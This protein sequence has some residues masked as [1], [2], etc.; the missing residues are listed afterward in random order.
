MIFGILTSGYLCL[1]FWNYTHYRIIK[2]NSQELF[3][4]SGAVGTAILFVGTFLHALS[5]GIFHY[6][7]I[8]LKISIGIENESIHSII[9]GIGACY[10]FI[11]LYNNFIQNRDQTVKELIRQNNDG[12]S[13]MLLN[14][15]TKTR[16]LA[17]TLSNKKVYIGL[18]LTNPFSTYEENKSFQILPLLSGYR[19]EKGEYDLTTVY[20]TI[21]DKLKEEGVSEEDRKKLF[22]ISLSVKDIVTCSYFDLETYSK[23]STKIVN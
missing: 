1:K 16:E 20:S 4:A 14:S 13:L 23:F 7:H 11:I 19:D 18:V 12:T 22:S 15:M 5:D 17:F 2:F 10:L 21:Y 6:L 3:L 9:L 8:F